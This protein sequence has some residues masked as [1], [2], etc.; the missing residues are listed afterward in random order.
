MKNGLDLPITCTVCPKTAVPALSVH[1]VIDKFNSF[2][3]FSEQMV[4]N[5][6]PLSTSVFINALLISVRV[7]SNGI[8]FN[9]FRL[10]TYWC[11]SETFALSIKN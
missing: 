3:S 9:S 8:C 10:F 6:F 5:K 11:S 2:V 4:P 1:G 7:N